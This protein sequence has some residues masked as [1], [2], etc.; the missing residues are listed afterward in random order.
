LTD[1][2]LREEVDT[3]MFEGHDTTAAALSF[4]IY[5]LGRHPQIQVSHRVHNL[6]L[7]MIDLR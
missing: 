3:F 2:D 6:T 7:V 5:L 4:T 1:E